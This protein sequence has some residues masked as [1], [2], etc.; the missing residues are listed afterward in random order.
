M[1]LDT[2]HYVLYKVKRCLQNGPRNPRVAF[3]EIET[4]VKLCESGYLL[5]LRWGIRY[6]CPVLIDAA[7]IV[8]A[9]PA[10]A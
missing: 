1:A 10:G 8:T 5:E 3:G 7:P 2:S 4:L 9:S 6:I